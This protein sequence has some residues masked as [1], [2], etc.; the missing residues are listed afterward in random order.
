[1]PDTKINP[2]GIGVIKMNIFSSLRMYA[3]KWNL[4]SSRGFEPEEIAAVASAT[5]VP[6]QYGNSVCFMMVGGGQTFIPLSQNS[7]KAVGDNIDLSTAKLLTL[8]KSGEADI[9]RVEA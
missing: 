6:S 7:S 2:K 4:K 5:V 9:Y 1:M 8:G 3:G